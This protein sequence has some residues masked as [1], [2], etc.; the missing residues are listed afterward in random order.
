M[1]KL[2]VALLLLSGTNAVVNAADHYISDIWGQHSFI[3]FRVTH[4]ELS[5]PYG[6][7]NDFEGEFTFDSESPEYFGVSVTID[8][9]SVNTNHE[10]CDQHLVEYTHVLNTH[11]RST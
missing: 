8:P 11:C 6:R 1:Q 4:L 2:I 9:A 3:E 5:W 7:F 10:R